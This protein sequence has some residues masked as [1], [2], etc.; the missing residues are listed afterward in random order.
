M[1]LGVK[2]EVNFVCDVNRF[3]EGGTGSLYVPVCNFG[4]G[5]RE[6]GKGWFFVKIRG[7]TSAH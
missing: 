1:W 5:E 3:R 4:G 2:E 7:R 6:K